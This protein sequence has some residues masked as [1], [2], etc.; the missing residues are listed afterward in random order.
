MPA[1]AQSLTVLLLAALYWH[2]FWHM[3]G[4]ERQNPQMRGVPAQQSV[5]SG[6]DSG[7]RCGSLLALKCYL[8]SILNRADFC[9]GIFE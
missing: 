4:T 7:A 2:H 3:C 9:T 8:E 6:S 5:A 1:P